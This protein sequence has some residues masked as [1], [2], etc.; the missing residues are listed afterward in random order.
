M[1]SLPA[2]LGLWD[3]ELSSWDLERQKQRL[4]PT[5]RE[6]PSRHP[7]TLGLEKKALF[8]SLSSLSKKGDR[9]INGRDVYTMVQPNAFISGLKALSQPKR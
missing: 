1:R 4:W 7:C 9:R 8:L 3:E 6:H 2:L 5:T